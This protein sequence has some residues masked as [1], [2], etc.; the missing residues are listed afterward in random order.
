[1]DQRSLSY[2]ECCQELVK[3]LRTEMEQWTKTRRDV[4]EAIKTCTLYERKLTATCPTHG[5]HTVK[6]QLSFVSVLSI[7]IDDGKF[8]DVVTINI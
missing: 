1:M 4:K 6:L 7:T 5:T 8:Q 3:V 2:K